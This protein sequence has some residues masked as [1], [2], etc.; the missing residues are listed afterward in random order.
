VAGSTG[1]VDGPAQLVSM[2]GGNIVLDTTSPGVVLVRVRYNTRWSVAEGS[3]CI[4]GTPSGWTTLVA[5]QAGPF[6][7]ALD[8]IPASQSSC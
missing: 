7:L 6:H 2:D 5:N 8:H 4:Y 1:I 3:G